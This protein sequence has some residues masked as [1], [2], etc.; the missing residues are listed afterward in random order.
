M[1]GARVFTDFYKERQLVI[2]FKDV[3]QSLPLYKWGNF[4]ENNTTEFFC[5]KIF[6]ILKFS[7]NKVGSGQTAACTEW[8]GWPW[9][10]LLCLKCKME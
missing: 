10:K 4:T 7:I 3:K 6:Y 1:L 2:V 9:G 8:A 5:D